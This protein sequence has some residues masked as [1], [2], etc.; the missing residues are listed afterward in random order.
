MERC[1]GNEKRICLV[2]NR[3]CCH[4]PPYIYS[5]SANINEQ[6]VELLLFFPFSFIMWPAS[7]K[8]PVIRLYTGTV[9]L[10]YLTQNVKLRNHF[11]S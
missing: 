5:N 3:F 11:L 6:Y 2:V 10:K 8:R 7:Y 1:V 4:F 9:L